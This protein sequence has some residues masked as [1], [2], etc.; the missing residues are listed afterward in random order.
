MYNKS[1]FT[2]IYVINVAEEG[3][4]PQRSKIG[5]VMH[6]VLN[7]LE[8]KGLVKSQLGEVTK[9]RG[10]KRKRCDQLTLPGKATLVQAK[11]MRDRLYD[12]IPPLAWTTV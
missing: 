6:K 12:R 11:S 7:R 2:Y 10:G 4:T 8:E 9:A 5:R 1:H 3:Y